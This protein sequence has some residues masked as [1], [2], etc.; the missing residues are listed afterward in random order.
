[1]AL[2]VERLVD[3]TDDVLIGARLRRHRRELGAERTARY[4]H[5]IGIEQPRVEQHPQ[6]LR[7]A[8]GRVEIDGDVTARRL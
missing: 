8:T 2:R 1:M 4:R 7:N 5:A 6:H 3:R